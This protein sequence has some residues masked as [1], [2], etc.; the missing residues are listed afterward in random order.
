MPPPPVRFVLAPGICPL[1]PHDSFSPRVYAPSSR[2]I[3]SGRE[4]RRGEMAIALTRDT[5]ASSDGVRWPSP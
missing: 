3:R 1:L 5:S 2:A 4:L